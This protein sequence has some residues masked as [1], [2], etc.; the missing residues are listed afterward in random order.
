MLW[1]E[2]QRVN[3]AYQP[4]SEANGEAKGEAQHAERRGQCHQRACERQGARRIGGLLWQV[5]K[6]VNSM[7]SLKGKSSG[8]VATWSSGH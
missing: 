2:Q 4:A 7:L 1:A 8:L 5:R 6:A 3:E